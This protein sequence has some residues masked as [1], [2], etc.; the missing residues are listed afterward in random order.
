[1]AKTAAEIILAQEKFF[2]TLPHQI[3]STA[4]QILG[5]EKAAFQ[6]ARTI[7]INLKQ[8]HTFLGF[9]AIK[10]LLY[11]NKGEDRVLIHKIVDKINHHLRN[12]SK[13]FSRLYYDFLYL[14]LF[15]MPTHQAKVRKVFSGYRPS[16]QRQAKYNAYQVLN[17]YNVYPGVTY[18]Q[19]EVK[20]LS[21]RILSGCI[22]DIEF[23]YKEHPQEL[24]F[25]HIVYALGHPAL[26]AEAAQAKVHLRAYGQHQPDFQQ[27][28]LYKEAAGIA[29]DL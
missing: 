4:L 22:A 3:V 15:D 18:F 26:A 21:E 1:M 12:K 8:I 2:S 29:V 24:T 28:A 23:Q 27:S 10:T 9:Q 7:L 11:S 5:N 6:A 19:A 25:G 16:A 14:P 13:G 20:V 17:C